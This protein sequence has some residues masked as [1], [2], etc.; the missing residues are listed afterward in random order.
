MNDTRTPSPGTP[1]FPIN[2]PTLVAHHLRTERRMAALRDS[3]PTLRS[4]FDGQPWDVDEMLEWQHSKY[5][6]SSGSQVATDFVLHV[7]N[8]CRF[9]FDLGRA[10]NVW[11]T[12]HREA[13]MAWA[14]DPWFA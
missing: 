2:E 3:F 4:R 9:P 6:T 10:L 7:W 1:G 11:D 8:Y 13:W 5:N 14:R 12:N